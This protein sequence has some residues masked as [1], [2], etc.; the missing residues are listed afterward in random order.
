VQVNIENKDNWTPLHCAVLGGHNEIAHML[1]GQGGAQICAKNFL[2][3]TALHYAAEKGH[4]M[5]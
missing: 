2:G 5:V 4:F 3:K 1:L